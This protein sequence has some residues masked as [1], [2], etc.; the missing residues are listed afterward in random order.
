M[1]QKLIF[2]SY[3]NYLLFSYS[4]DYRHYLHFALVQI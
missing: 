2:V 1:S 4:F 3:I